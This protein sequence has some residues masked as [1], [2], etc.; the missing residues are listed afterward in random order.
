FFML[1]R[2]ASGL[3]TFAPTHAYVPLGMRFQRPEG[4]NSLLVL[5]PSAGGLSGRPS[6]STRS[7]TSS[8]TPRSAALREVETTSENGRPGTWAHHLSPLRSSTTRI[9]GRTTASVVVMA[10]ALRATD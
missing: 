9:L 6:V 10:G 8:R 3:P 2:I 5:P 1:L 4:T 7:W